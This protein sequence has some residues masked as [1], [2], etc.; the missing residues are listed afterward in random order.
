[1]RDS[2]VPTFGLP[3]SP[4]TPYL[5]SVNMP[6]FPASTKTTR[7]L[8]TVLAVAV[9][10]LLLS[11]LQ[12]NDFFRASALTS[13]LFMLLV[14]CPRLPDL[15]AI[16]VLIPSATM[17]RFRLT[18][19]HWHASSGFYGTANGVLLVMSCIGF[20]TLLV[21]ALRLIWSSRRED[22]DATLDV[23]VAT[24]ILVVG[25]IFKQYSLDFA[26]HLRPLVLDLYTLSFDGSLGFQPSFAIGVMLNHHGWLKVAAWIAYTGILIAMA[27][28]HAIQVRREGPQ[29]SR[30]SILLGFL[31]IA[32]IGNGVYHLFPAVG[33]IY[34]FHGLFPDAPLPAQQMAHVNVVPFFLD[35][36]FPRNAVPSLHFSWALFIWWNLRRYGKVCEFFSLVF[37]GLTFLATL[38]LGE[39]Y[40]V[41]LVISFPF[42]LAIQALMT[43][44]LPLRFPPKVAALSFGIACTAAWLVLLRYGL[45]LFWLSPVIPWLSIA[46]TIG[47]SLYLLRP[48]L[49]PQVA[50]T[51]DV[52]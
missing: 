42:T 51:A 21:A 16:A 35:P 48:L 40:L 25:L 15:L 32:V 50:S 18:Y 44:R 30:F 38:G 22:R 10:W 47:F 45:N 19:E 14:L 20:V 17:L 1:M 33:P 8:A 5:E 28:A 52:R 29:G 4:H 12:V 31:V 26:S 41:D 23:I 13:A 3:R 43:R 46:L 2:T 49:K 11:R 36:Q 34:A 24:V 37:L 39:H 27:M 9:F 7:I 6:S